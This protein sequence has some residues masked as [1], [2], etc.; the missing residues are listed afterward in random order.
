MDGDKSQLRLVQSVMKRKRNRMTH[1]FLSLVSRVVDKREKCYV[2]RQSCLQHRTCPEEHRARLLP[3]GVPR[4]Q[5]NC[6]R[7]Q[8]GTT[9][10]RCFCSVHRS[11]GQSRGQL[12]H[13]RLPANPATTKSVCRPTSC[14]M[15]VWWPLT[16]PPSKHAKWP[17]LDDPA[18]SPL[19]AASAWRSLVV[20]C[21]P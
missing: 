14:R 3:C 4:A 21:A 11:G 7:T 19:S 16:M 18:K 1:R 13:A 6:A 2:Q 10:R 15:Q 5:T 8:L 9:T 20:P 12:G 17:T